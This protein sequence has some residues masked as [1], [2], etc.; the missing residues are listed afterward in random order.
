MESFMLSQSAKWTKGEITGD[1][2]ISTV[3]KDSREIK[4]NCL[5]LAISGENFD[6]H[7]YI[8]KAID[9][10][11]VAVLSHRKNEKY[12]VNTLYVNDTRQAILDIA[13]GY[14]SMFNC[15]ITAITGSVGKTTTRGLTESV[16]SQK[17]N[18][19]ATKGNLNNQLGMPLT[20]LELNHSHEA[21][22]I[23]MGMSGF[24][25]ILSMARCA[26]P[27]IAVITNIG[28]A[29]MEFLGSRE[30]I[31]KAKME[32]LDGLYERGGIAV[33]N[34]DE[35]LLFEKRD[36]IKAETIWFGI[37]NPECDVRAE[38]IIS[39]EDSVEFTAL[40]KDNKFKA[41]LNLAGV[42]NVSN[43]LVAVAVGFKLGLSCEQI[44]KGLYE[45]TP[46]GKRQRLYNKNGFTIYEDCYNASPDSMKAALDV[47]G[48]Q[49]GG[50]K[51]AVLGSMMEL[52]EY[53]KQG[54]ID[55]GLYACENA[56]SVYLYGA[57][58]DFMAEGAL[59]GGM[60]KDNIHIFTSH[61]D[62]AKDLIEKAKT[63]DVLLFKGSRSMKMEQVL[64]LF[65]GEEV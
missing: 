56:D 37:E 65:L 64:N 55:T 15:P 38:D 27:D 48:S 54:H 12:P 41:K 34:G 19:H 9:N 2:K 36:E 16:L 35:K 58:A 21:S 25:E 5:F 29:H 31:C 23:E 63:G 39:F 33:L 51:F 8:Q 32:I 20:L 40:Y 46:D 42:H 26:K 60:T 3:S 10:G 53:T 52:G 49:K 22:V 14:R 24:G 43:A 1:V 47:L 4:E 44:A 7:D 50:K 18:T 61:E 57:Y 11:A 62:M 17:Y 6:G 28:T 13:Q 45:Y 59:K 30:G